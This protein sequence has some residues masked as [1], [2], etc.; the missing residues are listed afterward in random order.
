MESGQNDSSDKIQTFIDGFDS[1]IGGGVKK[2]HVVLVAGTGA[3]TSFM[4]VSRRA[5]K[6]Y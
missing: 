2:G 6:A 5:R 3:S 1:K 4:S